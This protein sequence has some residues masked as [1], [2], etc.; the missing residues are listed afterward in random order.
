MLLLFQTRRVLDDSIWF[1]H[2]VYKVGVFVDLLELLLSPA[3]LLVLSTPAIHSFL[4]ASYCLL[5]FI[6]T[7]NLIILL[8]A[9]FSK[10]KLYNNHQFNQY[11]QMRS[12]AMRY[13]LLSAFT[14]SL[15]ALVQATIS[16]PKSGDSWVIGQEN[17]ISW[18][19]SST[20]GAVDISLC[21]AGAKDT[22]VVIA[23]IATQVDSSSGSYK[24]SSDKSLKA[25]SVAIVIVDSKKSY[26]SSDTF[27]LVVDESSS[28]SS[29]GKSSGKGSNS[30][31]TKGEKS[32]KY[33]YLGTKTRASGSIE[34]KVYTPG[35]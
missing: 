27:V 12:F 26:S 24:W 32:S 15:S 21:P 6:N 34:T 17:A 18:D 9:L 30:T 8:F 3:S 10:S 33:S 28:S 35:L 5:T 23:Q 31:E 19:S 20:S 29:S 16:S 13:L 1:L 25:G 14:I 4:L 22:T 11:I 2:I 7:I